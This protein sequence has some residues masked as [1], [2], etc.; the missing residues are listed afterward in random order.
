MIRADINDSPVYFYICSLLTE[1]LCLYGKQIFSMGGRAVHTAP[2]SSDN[3]GHSAIFSNLFTKVKFR[4]MCYHP[5]HFVAGLASKVKR[6]DSLASKLRYRPSRDELIEKHIIE[7]KHALDFVYFM[8]RKPL[9]TQSVQRA[10]ECALL[11]G[12]CAGA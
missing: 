4:G 1:I 6:S 10:L 2:I 7:S 11:I 12:S 8:L 5:S 3:L 9:I